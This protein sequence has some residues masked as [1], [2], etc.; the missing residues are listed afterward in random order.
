MT[1][2]VPVPMDKVES[3]CRR[4]KVRELSLFGSVLRSDF[5]PG[6]DVDVLVDLRPDHGL[7]LYDWVD[8][9][10]ELRSIFGR[11]VDLVAKS[12]LTN[13]IRRQI[14]LRSAEVLY[15]A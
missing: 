3:F 14:I 15:A 5:G 10:A 8:M 7:S 9:I 11:E 2:R 1:V 4:W 6:S 12:G 13:P